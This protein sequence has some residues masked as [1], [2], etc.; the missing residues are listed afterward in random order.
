MAPFIQ[1][2]LDSDAGRALSDLAG[3][4]YWRADLRCCTTVD[5]FD[6]AMLVEQ[7]DG[8]FV[9]EKVGRGSG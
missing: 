5:R 1:R 3:P 8:L 7:R 6:F 4:D 9:M 2:V